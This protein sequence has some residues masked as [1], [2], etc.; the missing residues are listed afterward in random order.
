MAKDTVGNRAATL[1]DTVV[2][3]GGAAGLSAALTLVRARRRVT[4]V[5]AGH[6]RNSPSAGVH[7]LLA[8]DGVS[9]SDLVARGRRE[10]QGYG[11]EVLDGE[12]VD[13]SVASHGFDIRLR[14]GTTLPTRTLL[15]ATGV[16]DEL[17]DI[18][19]VREQWGRGVLHCPYCHGWEVRDRRIG[20][21]VTGPKSADEATLFHQWSRDIVV[22]TGGARLEEQDRINLGALGIPIVSGGIS[23]V[24]TDGERVTGV[25]LE[26]DELVSVDAV[27]VSPRMK[28]P[29]EPF[30]ELGLK[31]TEVA[32]GSIIETD[33]FGTTGVPG[34]WAAGNTSDLM[35]QVGGAAAQGVK[36]A[37][38]INARLVLDDLNRTIGAR[39][40]ADSA[41]GTPPPRPHPRPGR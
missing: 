26:D 10:V 17:P 22:F 9:P 36:A 37:Q 12:V 27:V 30:T 39:E 20:V 35:A 16:V 34:V 6:P 13:A 38:H 23:R 7:G 4:V 2:V 29:L 1:R 5:D 25:R 11:G 3:G 41:E 31:A 40:E 32:V 14:D 28:A 19:G 15:I 33:E 24:E 18:P 21:L 8:L